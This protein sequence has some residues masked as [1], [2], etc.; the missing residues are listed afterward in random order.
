[1]S[2]STP[3]LT[4][5]SLS[6]KGRLTATKA[7]AIAATRQ[8]PRST[9][10]PEIKSSLPNPNSQPPKSRPPITFRTIFQKCAHYQKIKILSSCTDAL[11]GPGRVEGIRLPALD[12]RVEVVAWSDAMGWDVEGGDKMRNHE[13]CENG[14]NGKVS[15]EILC[16]KGQTY[17]VRI[18]TSD[19][20]FIR[21]ERI[22]REPP[23]SQRT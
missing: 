11:R 21:R 8:H 2:T 16:K 13:V 12:V 20:H 9:N 17:V 22:N 3:T 4:H 19:N 1:M 5:A 23:N 10:Q 14:E 18:H 15:A 6:P 7:A